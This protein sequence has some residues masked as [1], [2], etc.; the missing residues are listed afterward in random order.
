M[1][2]QQKIGLRVVSFCFVDLGLALVSFGSVAIGCGSGPLFAWCSLCAASWPAVSAH[3]T[4]SCP[5]GRQHLQ[6]SQEHLRRPLLATQRRMQRGNGRRRCRVCGG[7]ESHWGR[8]SIG[9]GGDDASSSGLDRSL[10]RLPGGCEVCSVKVWALSW[11][12]A[13]HVSVAG[14]TARTN[15]ASSGINTT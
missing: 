13:L 7:D 8:P 1:S 2:I 5:P 11:L 15:L 4:C 3:C 10:S 6:C 14:Q 9:E 12:R